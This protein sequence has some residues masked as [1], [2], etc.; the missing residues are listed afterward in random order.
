MRLFI[1]LSLNFAPHK[2]NLEG[3]NLVSWEATFT[4][5]SGSSSWPSAIL[6]CAQQ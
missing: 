5:T 4:S 3:Y 1:D 2:N 6:G